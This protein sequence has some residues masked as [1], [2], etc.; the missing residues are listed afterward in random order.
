M[1]VASSMLPWS[2]VVAVTRALEVTTWLT[3]WPKLS[4]YSPIR[5]DIIS[6]VMAS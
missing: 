3:A 5:T 1:V 6:I 4:T 2:L